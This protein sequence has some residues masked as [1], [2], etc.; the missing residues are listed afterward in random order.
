MVSG[1]GIKPGASTF[2]RKDPDQSSIRE[3][4]QRIVDCGYRQGDTARNGLRVKV[5]HGHMA[6]TVP[7]K[8]PVQRNPL[9]S[10]PQT[11]LPQVFGY[12]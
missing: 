9:F 4:V 8:K 6:M 1:V 3:I 7:E 11:R 10:R 12:R 5:F 2:H